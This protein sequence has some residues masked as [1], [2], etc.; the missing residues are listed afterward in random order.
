[1][2]AS[3][4]SVPGPFIVR[5]RGGRRTTAAYVGKAPPSSAGLC[6]AVAATLLVLLP[7]PRS[8]M[9]ADGV[10]DAPFVRVINA[11]RATRCAEEDNVY[12]PLF[13]GEVARFRIEATHPAYISRLKTDSSAPDFTGCDMRSD[14]AFDFTPRTVTLLD[15][16][17]LALVGHSFARFWRPE[18]VPVRVGDRTED[19][20]HLLQLFLRTDRGRSEFLVLYPTD[21][22]W[23][24]KPLPTAALVDG[25]YGSSF[26][27]GPIEEQGRPLVRLS[28]V[29]FE[30][31]DRT[32]HLQ[33]RS[34]GQ[35]IVHVDAI[36]DIRAVLEVGLHPPVKDGRPFAA[37]RSM[38]VSPQVA[39]VAEVAWQVEPGRWRIQEI[40]E[41]LDEPVTALRFGRSAISTHNSSAP[42]LLFEA[43]SKAP[44]ER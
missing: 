34:G 20:L 35:G 27:V 4:M 37:L 29:T 11:S 33:F 23:R 2:A 44:N 10:V 16:A 28:S 31:K 8:A 3:D 25:A 24:L 39:D 30:P 32:F 17:E 36:N 18:S 42:D 43:F 19:G 40:G 6:N 26:L 22:Y 12:A 7:V 1:M 5:R 41:P 15:T 13:G 38:F 14:P 21:G 9:A